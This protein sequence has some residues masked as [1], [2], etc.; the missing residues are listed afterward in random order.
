MKLSTGHRAERSRRACAL[1]L[2]LSACALLGGCFEEEK[3]ETFYG[4]VKPPRAQEFRWSDGGLPRVFDPALAA[5]PPDTD[6]VRALFEGLTDYDPQSLELVAAVAVRWES[7]PDRRRWTFHLRRDARWSNGDP[8]TAGD[9]VRSWQRTLRLGYRAPHAGLL[10]NIEGAES[11]VALVAEPGVTVEQEG[12]GE[13]SSRSVEGHAPQP[14]PSITPQ[15]EAQSSGAASPPAVTPRASP[16]SFGATAVDDFTLG[17]RLKRP[18]ENFPAL[19]AHP[20]FR[21]V[22]EAGA[23]AE[24]EGGHG[25]AEEAGGEVVSNGAFRLTRLAADTVELERAHD[26]W[27]AGSV[28]LERVRFV[29]A[30]DPEAALAAYREGEVDAVTNTAF[31]PLALKLLAPYKDFRRATYGALTYYGFNLARAP[32]NDRRVREALAISVSRE[33]LST[34]TLGGATQPAWRFLPEGA[35]QADSQL[36]ESHPSLPAEG[37]KVAERQKAQYEEAEE[38]AAPLVEDVERA[39]RLLAEAGFPRGAGFPRV[40][41]LINRNEQQRAVAQA[42]ASMWRE[43]LGVETEVVV[44]GWDEY[45]AA[46]WTGDYDVARLGVVLQTTDEAANMGN[47]LARLSPRAGEAPDEDVATDAAPAPSPGE[48]EGDARGESQEGVTPSASYTEAEALR[49]LPAFPLY[50]ASSHALVKPY[51][52]GFDANLLDA[53]SLKRVRLDTSWQMPAQPDK[54]SLTGGE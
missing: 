34:D 1:L 44:R 47:V 7:S 23:K 51:V 42:V 15:R 31:E 20:V 48:S 21:P 45:E 38:A 6:A 27:D 52:S 10:G 37:Q 30:R 35:S 53:P 22:H 17:V 12:A 11:A 28:A 13:N 9:F 49:E 33:R 18:D 3:G 5:A 2:A 54:V 14:S 8:V 26:Y 36:T 41:L 25:E 4:R 43:R 16:A 19:V 40:R 50:F 24:P 39:R 46:L 29:A 32:F